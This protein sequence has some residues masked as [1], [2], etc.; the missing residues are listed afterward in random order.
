MEEIETPDG[1]RWIIR[2]KTSVYGYS[3]SLGAVDEAWKVA[4]EVVEDGI[5]PTMAERASAQLGLLSTAHRM[6]TALVPSRREAAMAQALV[7]TDTLLLEWS[8]RGDAALTDREA[9]RQASPH[10][11]ARRERLVASQ[12][13]R[14]LVAGP[15]DD[16]DEPD[17]VE[18]F[19]SQWLNV[20]G[21]RW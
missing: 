13:E 14:A 1:S 11:T 12:H 9:W 21:P 10:W 17:P 15:S 4:P 18:A 7:P 19:R 8:A 2:G 16:P 3:A 5:E 20:W 6:A